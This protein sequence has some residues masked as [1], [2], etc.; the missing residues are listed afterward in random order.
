MADKIC[1]NCAH[2][3]RYRETH[4]GEC[5]SDKFVYTGA[6]VNGPIDGLGYWDD[7]SHAADFETGESF[8]CIHWAAKE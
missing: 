3:E 5:D 6:N 7:V 8:G 4:V 1:R 2:W